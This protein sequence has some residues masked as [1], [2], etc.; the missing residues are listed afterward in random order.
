MK[1]LLTGSEG[2]IGQ[3]LQTFLKDKHQ[4]ICIDKKTGN[5]LLTCDLNYEVDIVIHLAGLSGVRDSLDSPVDYWINNVVASHRL[6]KQFKNTRI[7]YASSSTAREPWRNPYA[8][9]KFYMEHIAPANTMGMRFTTVYGPGARE[10][11]FI[12]KLLKKEV[13]YIN[14]DHK[15]DF[16]HVSDILTAISIL[17]TNKIKK[18][19]VIDI[20][21]GVSHSLIDIL[22][23]LNIS[24]DEKRIGTMFERKDNQAQIGALIELGWKPE[25]NLFNYLKENYDN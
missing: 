13:T 19:K 18:R 25:I 7:L 10:E 11:M 12:P 22:N 16:I 21:T 3:N 6:F 8:M 2:F 23:H 24:V 9:S 15:R 20:G 4:L 1:I 5:D 17:M 14:S